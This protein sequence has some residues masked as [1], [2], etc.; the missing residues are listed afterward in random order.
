MIVLTGFLAFSTCVASLANVAK[1]LSV[2][3]SRSFPH[4]ELG[5]FAR[6]RG[7]TW[8]FRGILAIEIE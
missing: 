7:L 1:E 6:P 3:I 5:A 2:L 8:P 4:G